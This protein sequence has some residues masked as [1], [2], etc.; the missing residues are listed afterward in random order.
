M[1]HEQIKLELL[2][3]EWELGYPSSLGGS[4]GYTV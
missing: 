3:S 2:P 4:G 1:E